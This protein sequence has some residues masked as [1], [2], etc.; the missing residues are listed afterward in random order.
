MVSTPKMR[1]LGNPIIVRPKIIRTVRCGPS[2][3]SQDLP[4]DDVPPCTNALSLD[5]VYD[6]RKRDPEVT[7]KVPRIVP[8][9]DVVAA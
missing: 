7:M 6:F 2:V 3:R 9:M 5:E 8:C 1:Y 4:V